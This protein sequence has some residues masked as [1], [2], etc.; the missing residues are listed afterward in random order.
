MLRQVFL[1]ARN[2]QGIS[3][4]RTPSACTHCLVRIASKILH[5]V[6]H[7][8]KGERHANRLYLT[9]FNALMLLCV[10]SIS[11]NSWFC[12]QV[13]GTLTQIYLVFPFSWPFWSDSQNW[14]ENGAKKKGQYDCGNF[15]RQRRCIDKQCISKRKPHQV[16][17]RPS[18]G[19]ENIE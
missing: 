1:C 15:Q 6:A 5:I 11:F 7:A 4:M 18:V 2:D 19:S 16:I 10:S 17:A 9:M 14:F 3:L 8:A 12:T 13:Q